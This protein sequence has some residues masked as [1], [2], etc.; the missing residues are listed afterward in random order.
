MK[1]NVLLIAFLCSGIFTY[2]KFIPKAGITLSTIN[3]DDSEYSATSIIGFSAGL[4]YS[5]NLGIFS[6]QPEL[7]F[8]QKGTKFGYTYEEQDYSESENYD[9]TT[10]YIELPVLLKV[11]LGPD[12]LKFHINAGPSIGYGFGGKY[13]YD[14]RENY[15]GD[16]YTESEKGKIKFGNEPEFNESDDLYIDNAIDFGVQVGGGVTI[17]NKVM[18]DIRYGI[19][20]SDL[21]E[22]QTSKN[23][24]LQFTIGIPLGR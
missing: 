20:L 17:A 16:I 24:V 8:I 1:K 3:F 7:L 18:I 23:R 13:K 14:Y 11:S 10:N 15:F 6:V 19:G 22:E 9:V 5:L 12:A 21:F 2:A 4:A